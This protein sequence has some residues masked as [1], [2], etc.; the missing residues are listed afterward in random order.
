M[1]NVK[2]TQDHIDRIMEA[3]EVQVKTIYGKCTVVSIQLPNG[4]IITESSA[5]V[6][7]A[8][9]D[10]EMGKAICLERIENK[11]WEL[12]GYVL[13]NAEYASKQKSITG[14]LDPLDG[15]EA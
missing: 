11:I 12:E 2:I 1:S 8:N 9:Y 10:M 7:P 3:S 13:Q 6:D 5:C 15:G 4:F 14:L